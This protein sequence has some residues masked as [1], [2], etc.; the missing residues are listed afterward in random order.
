M[1]PYQKKIDPPKSSTTSNSF[2]ST[3]EYLFAQ[4]GNLIWDEKYVFYAKQ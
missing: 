3:N 2:K 1:S 4:I